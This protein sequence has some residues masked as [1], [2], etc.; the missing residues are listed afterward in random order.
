MS[1]ISSY[2]TES[3]IEILARAPSPS[4]PSSESFSSG[5]RTSSSSSLSSSDSS[6]SLSSGDRTSSSSSTK[7]MSSSSLSSVS[8]GLSSLAPE[9]ESDFLW[10]ESAGEVTITGYI[11]S[12]GYV[13]IPSTIGGNPVKVIGV[14]AFRDKTNIT[15]VV[16]P[17][18]VISL[19]NLC[20]YGCSNLE[21]LTMGSGITSIPPG[22][23]QYCSSLENIV[24]SENLIGASQWA[25]AYCTSIKN[26]VFPESFTSIGNWSFIG[27]SGLETMEFDVNFSGFQIE[28]LKDCVGL[29]SLTFRGNAPRVANNPFNN[30]PLSAKV[31]YYYG[32]SGWGPTLSTLTTECVDCTWSSSSSKS[33]LSTSS[34]TFQSSLSSASS[35]PEHDYVWIVDIDGNAI[36][37]DYIGTDTH[38]VI[39]QTLDTHPV[40]AIENFAFE[41]KSILISV[42]IPDCVTTL[43][44]SAFEGC[45]NLITLDLGNGITLIDNYAFSDCSSLTSLSIGDGVT[46][47]TLDAFEGTSSLESIVVSAGN[48]IFSSDSG[49]LY[50]KYQ[51]SLIKCPGGKTGILTL[52]S[53][54]VEIKALAFEECNLSGVILPKA[55]RTIEAYAFSQCT[56]LTSI[57]FLGAAPTI[58]AFSFN[59]TTG[60]IYYH[61]ASSPSYTSEWIALSG[62]ECI[63]IGCYQWE[64]CRQVDGNL[65]AISFSASYQNRISQS[66][67]MLLDNYDLNKI[68]LYLGDRR[69][70]DTGYNVII[71]IYESDSEG[72]P[73]TLL[74]TI[75]KPATD[76][77]S[78]GWYFFESIQGS[79]ARPPKGM[80]S[81]VYYQDGGSEE[82]CVPWYYSKNNSSGVFSKQTCHITSSG[83]TR[84]SWESVP[85]KSMI[86]KLITDIDLFTEAYE[87][88]DINIIQTASGNPAT[89]ILEGEEYLSNGLTAGQNVKLIES[90]N[91]LNE[92]PF[93]RP[94][95][96]ISNPKLITSLIVDGSGSMGWS[97]RRERRL[98]IATAIK[99]LLFETYP[100]EAKLDIVRLGAVQIEDLEFNSQ[101]S[102]ATIKIDLSIPNATVPNA[103]GSEPSL[104][105]GIIAYGFRDLE[106]N[107]EYII[108]DIFAA[109]ATIENGDGQYDTSIKTR[110]PLNMSSFGDPI[111]KASFAIDA[112]G[113]GAET[114]GEEGRYSVVAQLS[115]DVNHIRRNIQV[116]RHLVVSGLTSVESD[117]SLFIE[118]EDSSLFSSFTN[119]D[120]LDS[121][122]ANIWKTISSVDGDTIG[123]TDG[124]LLQVGSQASSLGG[125]AQESV[126]G[127]SIDLSNSTTLEILIK[128][129]N[130]SRSVTFYLQTSKG[131]RLEWQINPFEEWE[132]LL[133]YYTDVGGAI[134]INGFDTDRDP[135]PDG[136]EVQ[137]YVNSPNK[138][139]QADDEKLTYDILNTPV[140]ESQDRIEIETVADIKVG[141]IATL[142][143]ESGEE[144]EGYII[145]TILPEENIFI[146]FPPWSNSDGVEITRVEINPAAVV[147]T[148]ENQF[149][150]PL[151]AV[152]VTPSEV[153]RDIDPS[154]LAPYDPPRTSSSNPDKNLYN[155][156][157]SREIS[158]PNDFPAMYDPDSKKAY[159]SLNILP[160][161]EDYL[162]TEFD[163]E[164]KVRTATKKVLTDGEKSQLE[165]LEEL[166]RIETQ[167]LEQED[168]SLV[169]AID[170][171]IVSDQ[172]VDEDADYKILTPVLL[173]G[174]YAESFMQTFATE[175]A[176]LEEKDIGRFIESYSLYGGDENWPYEGLCGIQYDLY[177]YILMKNQLGAIIAIKEVTPFPIFFASPYQIWS[178]IG[179]AENKVKFHC[180]MAVP[181]AEPGEPDTVEYDVFLPGCY[182]ASDKTTYIDYVVT[183]RGRLL[184]EGVLRIKIFD[185][186]R[187]TLQ[188]NDP[189]SVTPNFLTEVCGSID[190]PFDVN[191]QRRCFYNK[192]ELK[193]GPETYLSGAP[194][195]EAT[196]LEDYTGEFLVDIVNGRARIEIKA[197]QSVVAKILVV[198]EFVFPEDSYQSV[199]KPDPIWFPCPLAIEYYGAKRFL[200]GHDQ[201]LYEIGA[202]VTYMEE[203][204]EDNVIVEFFSKSHN[205][206]LPGQ[207]SNVLV[208]G[209]PLAAPINQLI[210]Q[211][212]DAGLPGT[213]GAIEALEGRIANFGT[214]PA[215]PITPKI[216]KTTG[217]GTNDAGLARNVF[218]GTHGEVVMH[219][220]STGNMEKGDTEL[221]TLQTSYLGFNVTLVQPIEW[222][223]EFEDRDFKFRTRI[224]SE[225]GAE[226]GGTEAEVYA[227][228]WKGIIVLAD[229]ADIFPWSADRYID[230]LLGEDINGNPVGTGRPTGII[231]TWG[232]ETFW[233][234]TQLRHPVT[235]QIL[236]EPGIDGK[237][238]W[239]VSNLITRSAFIDPSECECSPQSCCQPQCWRIGADTW[240]TKNGKRYWGVGCPSQ[241]E[242]NC[243]GT[244]ICG[245]GSV[246]TYD[247]EVKLTWKEPLDGSFSTFGN[248]SLKINRD[249]TPTSVVLDVTFSGEA[250]PLVAKRHNVTDLEGNPLSPPVI[251]FD[252][253]K[254]VKYTNRYGGESTKIIRDET[255]RL[256]TYTDVAIIE[257]T[258]TGGDARNHFHKCQVDANGNGKTTTT[259]TSDGTG[260]EIETNHVHTILN[261][262]VSSLVTDGD[263]DAHSHI[264][265]SVARTTI[266]PIFEDAEI[267]IS[268]SFSYDASKK[269]VVRKK[270]VTACVTPDIQLD[271]YWAV[272]VYCPSEYA[273]QENVTPEN[274]GLPVLA[275]VSHYILGERVEI[276]DGLRVSLTGAVY[277]PK[278][279]ENA[280]GVARTAYFSYG[281]TRDHA[282]IKWE[283]SIDIDGIKYSDPEQM[284]V[285]TSSFSWL[286]NS[287]GLVPEATSDPV[288]LNPA[289]SSI[290][291][292]GGSP[293][294]DA[295][296][297]AA[298]RIIS[299]KNENQEWKD[300]SSCMVLITDGDENL[301]E[302]TLDQ[303]I[304]SVTRMGGEGDSSAA[305]VALG[306]LHPAD[307]LVLRKY[308]D[309]TGG[310]VINVSDDSVTTESIA[311]RIF[312]KSLANANTGI[313]QNIV[314]LSSSKIH[315]S[316]TIEIYIPSGASATFKARFGEDGIRWGDWSQEVDVPISGI[317]DTSS[318]LDGNPHRYMQY[319]IKMIGNETFQAPRLISISNSYI[320]PQNHILFFA[321]IAIE[322]NENEYV[323]E[324]VITHLATVPQNSTISYGVCHLDSQ[325]ITDYFS[326]AQP[327]METDTRH[328]IL[329]RY[330]E[331]ATSYD[332]RNFSLVNGPWPKIAELE[333]YKILFGAIEEVPAD[334]YSANPRQGL[335]TMSSVQHSDAK[336]SVT[337]K[338]P[339]LIRIACMIMNYGTGATTIKH[340]GV[341]YN[342]VQR[343]REN[344]DGSINRTPIED[345]WEISSSSSSSSELYAANRINS[346]TSST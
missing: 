105:D 280:P 243:D 74:E 43:G 218:L 219:R 195:Q 144:F 129:K 140:L 109:D 264:L 14:D 64:T 332:G 321:P 179:P 93:L 85:E 292:L 88:S 316:S 207:A 250:I 113:P 184:K 302:R 75:S 34:W 304:K 228:G 216:S 60:P 197:P 33:S 58:Y 203:P 317:V 188:M 136:T 148:G 301:S 254:K 57:E 198:A 315:E 310:A 283:A 141:D 51:T 146:I 205:R 333:V 70:V 312:S 59:L 103:D 246:I 220:E 114:A 336:L 111:L 106:K 211:L 155:I 186:H 143:A 157:A 258:T 147:E 288:Y 139:F 121:D 94:Y 27:C 171:Y 29:T 212:D 276:P 323:G 177:P 248:D 91:P 284:T 274:N 225:T 277:P 235:N 261:F 123:L 32:T 145:E 269:F 234:K 300:S 118:I 98:E 170:K 217:Y 168:N 260:E 102:Y 4:S 2:S 206:F 275:E 54:V 86:M 7:A 25:F 222:I 49:V 298:A 208:S 223:G 306:I 305:P 174:G 112:V 185:A 161:T 241:M 172:P 39:P 193:D 182:P 265:R 83:D 187:T 6:Q 15:G 324:V 240:V 326:D 226:Y 3:S 9:L 308:A 337:L 290:T 201:P 342:V 18:E 107:H 76:F 117:G 100:G 153:G 99:D 329:G 256:S 202:I 286:P 154:V 82:N 125:I 92:D 221:L 227:D 214:W 55:I 72:K 180:V 68:A 22:A 10:I 12:G 343:T 346:E 318:L 297:L 299:F 281:Q 309:E 252:I 62:L 96:T 81:I 30:V 237:R 78:E 149:Y 160:I 262:E 199:V 325:E 194:Y 13:V 287:K 270:T 120:I 244:L 293:V 73:N 183:E 242:Q 79:R 319:E 128:D 23:F 181:D 11:G 159:V 166:Y 115:G 231:F 52:T 87:T 236:G 151:S 124:L 210:G 134:L 36:I 5:D 303:G 152:D 108:S 46:S 142:I 245:G 24:W 249:G 279:R 61:L 175:L 311:Q 295:A 278:D 230:D 294:H 44:I 84:A 1:E 196:Y 291:T 289:L 176:W 330:N 307:M 19:S 45:E 47:I 164:E 122:N 247:I 26:I 17:N 132:S 257:L 116:E 77:S 133:Y 158:L 16:I 345:V 285:V 253:Y 89:I 163:K 328:I 267:C 322:S 67:E 40:V 204:V 239:A 50:D 200:S 313:F 80:L 251:T 130:V 327:L 272:R 150:L 320:E 296:Y 97:D 266:L 38:I 138:D 314:D 167:N 42:E 131:G 119:V 65:M 53:D 259:Y 192:R 178:N 8:S 232:G 110:I 268:A 135:L 340:I 63:C 209:D 189:T 137:I 66:I 271:D 21:S 69:G 190:E 224:Y 20:F 213:G 215:T 238:G 191:I 229:L 331:T 48:E 71:E 341:T 273:V 101:N 233:S 173:F 28:S 156:D 282:V 344:T 335:I 334:Q 263:L 338:F 339:P 56:L 41:N 169:E 35:P 165:A 90:D 95:V 31:Y 127:K 104:S 37:T 162:D 255:T 126:A